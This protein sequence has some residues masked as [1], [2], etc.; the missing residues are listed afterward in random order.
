MERALVVEDMQKW[1]DFHRG[2][3]EPILGVGN[4]DVVANYDATIPL[5]DRSYEAYILDVQFPRYQCGRPLLLGIKL[6]REIE[7]REGSYNKIVIVSSHISIEAR[8]LGITKI[9]NKHSLNADKN[10]VTAFLRDL[11]SLLSEGINYVNR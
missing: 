4:V 9:Y 10:E 6:A 8:K 2:L 11:Q 3:L 7:Q 5:L 1:Q